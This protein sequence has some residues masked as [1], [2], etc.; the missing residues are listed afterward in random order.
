MERIL[1]TDT[2]EVRYFWKITLALILTIILIV[3]SR[4]LLILV[5]QQI[6]ILQGMTLN[7][8][9]QNAQVFVSESS[10]GQAI[11]S[12]L[13]LALILLL[14]F[15]LVTRIEKQEFHLNDFGLNLQRNTLP[16]VG[17][18]LIT[19]CTLFLGAALVGVF[20]GTIELPLYP[21]FS[22]WSLLTTLIASI[23]FYVLNSFWQE[24]L[25]RGYLQTRAVNEFG[26][27][28][29]VITVTAIFVIFHG[30][31]QTLTLTG[32]LTG[33]LLFSFIGLLYDKTKSLYLVAVIHAVLNF[34]PALF[35]TWW[36][37]LEAVP[38]YG[39][40]LFLL[41]LAIQKQNRDSTVI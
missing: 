28:I 40:A 31:V 41:S 4:V 19:G 37:L 26:Q 22:Q 17:L 21:D 14:V 16:F 15:F 8:A 1:R 10:E 38:I 27:S 3:I 33:F 25:F 35:D 2:G 18:G 24:I 20:L 13:D 34:L 39:I 7:V 30:L 29:G 6:F 32:I 9:S 11:A 23:T 12:A 5:V 36:Q